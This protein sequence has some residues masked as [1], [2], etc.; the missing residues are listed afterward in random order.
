[1]TA[2]FAPMDRPIR[3]LPWGGLVL[4]LLLFG[5]GPLFWPG[6]LSLGRA[7]STP[8]Y[9]HGPL[10]P[11]ISAWL[12]LRGLRDDPDPQPGSRWPGLLVV[13]AA[14]AL[15]ALGHLV[16]IDDVVTYAFIL[17]LGGVVLVSMG[18]ARG[19]RHLLAVLHLIFML[20]LPQFVFWKLTIFLQLTSS[21]IG[22][23]VISTMG[24][25]VFLDGN[26]IDLG[27]YKL[28]VAEACSGLR[29]LFPILSFSYLFGILYRGPFWHK[30]VLFLTAAPLTVL[31]NAFRIGMIGV[32]V[33]RYGIAQA[34]G[35][36]HVF[37][38]WVIFGACIA[39]LFL[40]ALGLQRL[41]PARGRGTPLLDLETEGL[42]PPLRRVFALPATPALWAA[43]VLSLGLGL[44]ALAGGAASALAVDGSAA[45]L[46]LATAGA[47]AM[48]QGDRFQTRQGDAFAVLEAL[49]EEGAQFD[50]VI[51]DP[52]AFAPAKPALE[53]GLRAYERVARLAAPLVAPGGYLVLC[54]CSHA[55]DLNAFRNASARGIGRGGRRSQ[56][57][58]TGFAG[59]DHPVLPQLAEGGYLKSLFFRL[60]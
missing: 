40:M 44:A 39:I 41:T 19:R 42:W 5:G 31:M 23:W 57:L 17:W 35:F 55:A 51:C 25:P 27:V 50:V 15:A 46:D 34:E 21:Q 26:I 10:I 37:E 24:I 36:L 33:D 16:R 13:A 52:P 20:P 7:W 45:A 29:Y 28:Q 38:G 53:A 30:A 18:F 11:L 32:L 14:L 43:A 48:G 47:K 1:M 8:E 59:A 3:T 2:R 58:H 60:D 4:A 49:G 12:F 22:V 6:L 54:S 56:I 9:S